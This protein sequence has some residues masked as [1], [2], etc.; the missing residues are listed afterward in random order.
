MQDSYS[1]HAAL[2]VGRRHERLAL[3]CEHNTWL[4][5]TLT[6][7]FEEMGFAVATASNGYSGLRM[8]IA[9]CPNIVVI[10]SALPELSSAQLVEE[11]AKLRRR[12][13]MQMIHTSKIPTALSRSRCPRNHPPLGQPLVERAAVAVQ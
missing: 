1:S 7:L 13:G 4:R 6:S 5:L 12:R 11:L 3:I 8:A 2:S 9:L 10:G